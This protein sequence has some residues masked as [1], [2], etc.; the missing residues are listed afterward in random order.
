MVPFLLVGVVLALVFTLNAVSG[1]RVDEIL[2]YQRDGGSWR[3]MS[4]VLVHQDFAH[5]ILNL[6]GLLAIFAMFMEHFARFRLLVFIPLA[7]LAGGLGMALLSPDVYIT[8]GFS[9]VL[10]GLFIAGAILEIG[11]GE[12]GRRAL[13]VFMA[14][15]VV[16]KVGFDLYSLPAGLAVSAHAGGASFGLLWAT[17]V[18][19]R[20]RQMVAQ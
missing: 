18:I 13:G 4:Y 3:L 7:A 11:S 12:A 16:I 2:R 20:Q 15:A 19:I 10:Y 1:Q 6:F 5:L 14:V 9:S 8:Y 17:Y